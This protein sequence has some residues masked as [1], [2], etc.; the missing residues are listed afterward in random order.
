MINRDNSTSKSVKNHQMSNGQILKDNTQ[1]KFDG[2]FNWMVK[3]RIQ[4]FS[5]GAWGAE[6]LAQG[7]FWTF[8]TQ[9]ISPLS[10]LWIQRGGVIHI[11]QWSR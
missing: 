8:V 6:T 5:H 11:K 2:K 9:I 7:Y 1:S 4:E 10:Q 3:C